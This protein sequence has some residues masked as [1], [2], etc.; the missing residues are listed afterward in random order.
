MKFTVEQVE[1]ALRDADAG[2]EFYERYSGRGM[3]GVECPGVEADSVTHLFAM[4]VNLAVENE[5]MAR[6]LARGAR[7]DS[8]GTGVIC[9]WPSVRY[10]KS[11]DD[12]AAQHN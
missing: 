12:E 2:T 4:F 5:E 11:V 6:E 7:M 9:Y 8:M 3:Y 1:A 10:P